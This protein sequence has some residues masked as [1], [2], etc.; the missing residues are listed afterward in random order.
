MEDSAATEPR[1][2]GS[3]WRLGRSRREGGGGCGA[4]APRRP[5]AAGPQ[6]AF[7]F[8]ELAPERCCRQLVPVA[9]AGK[10]GIDGAPTASPPPPPYLALA[11][12]APEL[13]G[14]SAALW[15]AFA[16]GSVAA[17]GPGRFSSSGLS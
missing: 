4:G 12:C 3:L 6:P 14:W 9:A 7:T 13:G 16:T 8:L 17:W 10:P 1:K 5:W 2:A 11:L 15:K